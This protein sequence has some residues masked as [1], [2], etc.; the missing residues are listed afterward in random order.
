MILEA[1]NYMPE[2]EEVLDIGQSDTEELEIDEQDLEQ[3][4]KETGKSEEEIFDKALEIKS[5]NPSEIIKAFA[6]EEAEDLY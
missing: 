6:D 4:Q 1:S 3:I 5:E 2:S